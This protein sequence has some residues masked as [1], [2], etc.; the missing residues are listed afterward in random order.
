MIV[1]NDFDVFDA[2]VLHGCAG[3]GKAG[4]SMAIREGYE[5]T[6]P[7]RRGKQK[8][9]RNREAKPQKM[10][11]P[12]CGEQAV[13]TSSREVYGGRDYGMIYLCRPCQAWVGCHEESAVPLGRIANAELRRAKMQAHEAFDPLWKTGEMS[14]HNAYAWL[15]NQ[16]GIPSRDCHIGMFDVEMCG[17]VVNVC[18][19]RLMEKFV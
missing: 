10:T 1:C 8:G 5:M 14:R 16:L 7:T 6:K 3:V 15:S 12:Y 19:R 11:C 13:F 18:Q 4:K 9:N 2:I 17:R